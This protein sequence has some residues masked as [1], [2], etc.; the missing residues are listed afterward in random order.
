M[1]VYLRILTTLTLLIGGCSLLFETPDVDVTNVVFLGFDPG[2]VEVE[3]LASVRNPNGFDITMTG[4]TYDLQVHALPFAD[5]GSS[6]KILFR[7]N[8][9]TDVRLPVRISF[10]S[11]Y[12]LLRRRPDPDRIPYRLVGTLIVETPLGEQVIPFRTDNHFSVPQK[13]RPS[14]LIDSLGAFFD[15]MVQRWREEPH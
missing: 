8:E 6:R 3:I 4:Y 14:S 11:L 5:G 10:R 15:G 9:T 13:Y 7:S 2:G 1:E 12:E